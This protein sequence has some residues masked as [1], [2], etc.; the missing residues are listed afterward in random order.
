MRD[1]KKYTAQKTAVDFGL[2]SGGLWNK[3]YDRQEIY[4]NEVFNQKLEYIHY[5]P[6]K[7]K[8]VTKAEN[9]KWSSAI[10]YLT[11]RNSPLPV[12]KQ[13]I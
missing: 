10:D 5:N 13:W 12:Q 3:G 9:W 2:D 7:K 1:F 6:V 8:L 11:E 4:S